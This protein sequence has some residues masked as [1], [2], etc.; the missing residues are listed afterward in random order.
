MQPT[1]WLINTARGAIVDEEALG[2]ALTEG[3]IA[4]AALDVLER[5]PPESAHPLLALPNVIVTPHNGATTP[6][7][8]QRGIDIFVENLRRYQAGQPLRNV[9]DK[10]AGY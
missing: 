1:A 9:V 4:G 7:T 8:R 6:Q 10:Q 5:E 3:W 2:R